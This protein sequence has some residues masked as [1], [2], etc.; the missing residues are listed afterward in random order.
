M[1][2]IKFKGIN[3][4]ADPVS[5]K[6]GECIDITDAY[7]DNAKALTRRDGYTSIASGNYANG[8]SNGTFTYCTVGTA[9]CYLVFNDSLGIVVPVA[10]YG[11][12]AIL[13]ALEFKQVNNVVA[14]SDGNIAGILDGYTAFLFDKP[15]FNI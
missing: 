13:G 14:F 5:L 1:A 10:V 9:L 12:G 4:T 11:V 8:W 7:F 15:T 6:P 3:N 2:T